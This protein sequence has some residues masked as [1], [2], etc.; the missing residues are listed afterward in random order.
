MCRFAVLL[1]ALFFGVAGETHAA[2]K[3]GEGG[4]DFRDLSGTIDEFP[5]AVIQARHLL[6]KEDAHIIEYW[7]R[8]AFA[9]K[10]GIDPA[11]LRDTLSKFAPGRGACLAESAQ[12]AFAA[13]LYPDAEHLSWQ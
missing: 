5:A 3:S 7:V 4:L 1:V 11:V 2:K 8:A 13:G 6:P 12:I 9:K 10:P